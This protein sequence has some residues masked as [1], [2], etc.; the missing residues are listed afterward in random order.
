V[1]LIQALQDKV[2]HGSNTDPVLMANGS[3]LWAKPLPQITHAVQNGKKE[4]GC[5]VPSMGAVPQ[6]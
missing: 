2:W 5:A 3:L 6:C 1:E 4:W